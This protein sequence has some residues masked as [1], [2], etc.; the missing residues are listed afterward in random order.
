MYLSVI[1]HTTTILTN[2]TFHFSLLLFCIYPLLY[3]WWPY[4]ITEFL[5]TLGKPFQGTYSRSQPCCLIW[6]SFTALCTSKGTHIIHTHC[7]SHL[8]FHIFY[9][10]FFISRFLFHV[11]YFTLFILCFYFTYLFYVLKNCTDDIFFFF[12][13]LL[14]FHWS[15]YPCIYIHV[16]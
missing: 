12:F 16:K 5:F 7:I 4:W 14:F 11:F 15:I 3:L 13:L 6:S 9:F 8:L 10:M 1:L 2:G